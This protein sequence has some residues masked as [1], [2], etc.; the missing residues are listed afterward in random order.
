[1]KFTLRPPNRVLAR[2]LETDV[3]MQL[4]TSDQQARHS[5][6]FSFPT[7]NPSLASGNL[8]QEFTFPADIRLQAETPAIHFDSRGLVEAP[9]RIQLVSQA[10]ESLQ[11]TLLVE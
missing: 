2:Q 11:E 6:S 10:D 4:E 1:M 7:R 9:L 5:I 3:V 8:P